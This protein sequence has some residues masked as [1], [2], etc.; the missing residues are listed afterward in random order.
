M[1]PQ[2]ANGACFNV[3]TSAVFI[4]DSATHEDI[5]QGGI[6]DCWFLSALASLAVDL[7]DRY[8]STTRR[9]LIQKVLQKEHNV[10]AINSGGN[11]K[12]KVWGV[13]V[14]FLVNRIL[15]FVYKNLVNQRFKSTV[16]P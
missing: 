13:N 4:A 6:G 12:F 11:F 3:P 16:S 9:S 15:L 2:N 8:D 14:L 7:P 5:T 1:A 10:A